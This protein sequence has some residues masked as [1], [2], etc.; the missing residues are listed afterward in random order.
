MLMAASAAALDL[1]ATYDNVWTGTESLPNGDLPAAA[2]RFDFDQSF[3]EDGEFKSGVQIQADIFTAI[4]AY[5]QHVQTGA[6]LINELSG[7][8]DDLQNHILDPVTPALEGLKNDVEANRA[9]I[10]A[11]AGN[12]ENNRQEI[13][14]ANARLDGLAH[15][16]CLNHDALRLFCHRFLFSEHLPAEC[17]PILHHRA[18][19]RLTVLYSWNGAWNDDHIQTPRVGNWACEN[20]HGDAEEV[21]MPATPEPVAVEEE[22]EVSAIPEEESLVEDHNYAPE[23]EDEIEYIV[24]QGGSQTMLG[25][26]YDNVLMS[27]LYVG[28]TDNSWLSLTKYK[29]NVVPADENTM[30]EI[31]PSSTAKQLPVPEG[32][33]FHG[34]AVLN[35]CNDINGQPS[36]IRRFE[37]AEG[38]DQAAHLISFECCTLPRYIDGYDTND[39]VNEFIDVIGDF[40]KGIGY[41]GW[42][43]DALAEMQ[44]WNGCPAGMYLDG[45]QPGE[46]LHLVEYLRCKGPAYIH[47]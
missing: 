40:D 37:M 3:L 8:S 35:G 17:K 31:Q 13:V 30:C 29:Y 38:G 10:E 33:R 36:Y 5:V 2:D 25:L 16:T 6:R 20:S 34:S 43:A 47:Y 9:D 42:G 4:E 44:D 15:R 32:Y 27:W 19:D 22:P 14:A 46:A 12:I 39:T 18:H 23:G 1:Q 11:N 41:G 21:T 45:I 26:D 24:P 7:D 28:G